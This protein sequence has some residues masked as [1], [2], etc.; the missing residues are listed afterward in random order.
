MNEVVNSMSLFI[1]VSDLDHELFSS[2]YKILD[3]Y[4]LYWI[5]VG[6]KYIEN[7]WNYDI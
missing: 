5:D 6:R 7:V 1:E 3:T 2:I 4:H